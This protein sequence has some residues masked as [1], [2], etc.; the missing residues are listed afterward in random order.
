MS[1]K[2]L[3]V[4]VLSLCTLLMLAAC[5]PVSGGSAGVGRGEGPSPLPPDVRPTVEPAAPAAASLSP[6]EVAQSYY[7]W[8]LSYIGD[9]AS[10]SMRNPLVDRAY[11]GSPYLSAGLIQKID[12]FLGSPEG[13][14]FDPFLC[15]Q[16]IP[17]SITA[18]PATIEGDQARLTVETSFAGHHFEVALHQVAGE[19]K[20]SDVTCAAPTQASDSPS[21]SP[22]M[23][24]QSFY[25]WWIGFVDQSQ[26]AGAGNPLIDG[27]YADH[28]SVAPELAQKV[29]QIVAGFDQGG[30]DPFL[31][32]QDLPQIV[33][34]RIVEMTSE[35]AEVA[36]RETWTGS[37][38]EVLVTLRPTLNGSWQMVDIACPGEGP[39]VA[40]P[41]GVVRAYYNW[42]LEYARHVGNPMV[43][44][45]YQNGALS[46]TF[47]AKVAD[48]LAT[49]RAENKGGF[50]PLL[51]AQDLPARVEIS[52][53]SESDAKA[54]V[55]V[56]QFFFF[57]ETPRLLR[58]TLDKLDGR[59]QIV[60]IAEAS[61]PPA[62]PQAT[63]SDLTQAYVD[64]EYH[65][66][67]LYPADWTVVNVPITYPDLN[68]PVVKI[69]QLL[70]AEWA[71]KLPAP[72]AT[73]DPT[74]L[75]IIAPLSVEVSVGTIEEYRRMYP[76]PAELRIEQIAGYEV[77]VEDQG[78]AVGYVFQDAGQPDLRVTLVDLISGFPV[79]AEGNESVVA[80]IAAVLQS[81][82]FIK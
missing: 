10:E 16:D 34:Y 71:A 36:V 65:F 56:S 35:R 18:G 28:V 40:S 13:G 38:Q 72:G 9:R 31:C 27:A 55:L 47:A 22:E 5:A 25:Q 48:L 58:V 17:D 51:L 29:D 2:K 26:Q 39:D 63:S 37:Y 76:E 66:Q 73:P 43:D 53:E 67:F 1:R 62:S 57:N 3:I 11:A 4:T 24:V 61:R 41:A 50:D 60:D 46:E 30:Y 32:A 20:M 19:W 69:V 80:V 82:E 8:Y 15:A 75:P 52:L 7:D 74:A 14:M 78:D 45:A 23:I 59:W 12:G 68:A 33:S 81:F 54:T 6:Q 42:Y 44:N 64:E 21:A 70:P 79:R 77:T 49:M